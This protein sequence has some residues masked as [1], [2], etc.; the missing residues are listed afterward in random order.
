MG[1]GGVT[2]D[3]ICSLRHQSVF[4][5]TETM[6]LVVPSLRGGASSPR[7]WSWSCLFLAG[8]VITCHTSSVYLQFWCQWLLSCAVVNL[9]VSTWDEDCNTSTV[10]PGS[11]WFPHS[12]VVASFLWCSPIRAS[13]WLGGTKQRGGSFSFALFAADIAQRGPP[14]GLWKISKQHQITPSRTTLA[15]QLC[16]MASCQRVGPPLGPGCRLS[17]PSSPSPSLSPPPPSGSEPVRDC[18]AVIY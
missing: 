8:L 14:Y 5:V 11:N 13:N 17:S 3:H 16:D 18:Y 15:V 4:L 9:E 6:T 7:S 1:Y 10:G 2:A 12:F